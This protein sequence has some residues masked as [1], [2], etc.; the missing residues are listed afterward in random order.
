MD[1][2]PLQLK[3][4]SVGLG[5]FNQDFRIIEDTVGQRRELDSERQQ[6]ETEEQRRAREVFPALCLSP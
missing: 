2:I 6:R 4:D 3:V 1:P 5:K